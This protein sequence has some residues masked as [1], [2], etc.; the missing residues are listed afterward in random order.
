M[1]S[2]ACCVWLALSLAACAAAPQ[3]EAH[4][5]PITASPSAPER[6]ALAICSPRAQLAEQDA[7]ASA[8]AYQDARNT[9]GPT[10]YDC[11]ST[12]TY[13]G[14]VS[15]SNTNCRPHQ[16]VML[17][18]FGASRANAAGTQAGIAVLTSCLA[19]YGWGIESQCIANCR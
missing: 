3:Y 17:N 8:Q 12:G 18:P 9:Q 1:R 15:S 19:E 7:R 2:A 5:V 6:Q 13:G 4:L 10:S 11:S 16:M 14:G